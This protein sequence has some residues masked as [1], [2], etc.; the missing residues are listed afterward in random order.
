MH[1]ETLLHTL[2]QI[3]AAVTSIV[4]MLFQ[5][6]LLAVAYTVC[7]LIL[8]SY[9]GFGDDSTES[10]ARLSN[11]NDDYEHIFKSLAVAF[12]YLFKIFTEQQNSIPF[13]DVVNSIGEINVKPKDNDEQA[14]TSD[15]PNKDEFENKHKRR[16]VET[17]NLKALAANDD[18]GKETGTDSNE[19]SIDP[20]ELERNALLVQQKL[21]EYN[22]D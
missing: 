5:Y 16:N 1:N 4:T 8:P 10:P 11:A 17:N 6:R 19:N 18:V 13:D 3:G 9:I 14:Q 20:K 2:R 7:I 15:D 22:E 21:E 12:E